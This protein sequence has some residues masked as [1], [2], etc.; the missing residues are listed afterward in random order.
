[1]P[2]SAL[3]PVAL[4]GIIDAFILREG[5]DYGERETEH[6]TKVTQ[7]RRQLE[8]GEIKIVYDLAQESVTLM[9]RRDWEK[10]APPGEHDG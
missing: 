7:I 1:M 3:S 8:R 5:T 10:L 4:A 9:T 2:L 6:E